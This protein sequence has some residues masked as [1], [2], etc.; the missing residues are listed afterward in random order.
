MNLFHEQVAVFFSIT[1]TGS[2]TDYQVPLSEGSIIPLRQPPVE[3]R[4][5]C[6]HMHGLRVS[7]ADKQY[8]IVHLGARKV[9]HEECCFFPRTRS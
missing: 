6:V 8:T 4:F 9:A 5:T 2:G 7:V 3:N 1:E